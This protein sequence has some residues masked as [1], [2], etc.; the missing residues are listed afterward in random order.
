[1]G[2]IFE[3]KFEI[4]IKNFR[5]HIK[6]W[7]TDEEQKHNKRMAVELTLYVLFTKALSSRKIYHYI[8]KSSE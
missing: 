2:N 6:D 7:W 5:F 4:L 1:M 3:F 8:L